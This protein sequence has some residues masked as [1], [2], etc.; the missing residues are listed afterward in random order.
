M[1]D[2]SFE[3]LV[4]EHS[5]RV[6]NCA[7][8]ILGNAELADD[9]HQEVFMAIW[10]RWNKYD[11]QVKWSAYLYKVTVRKAIELARRS[12]LGPDFGWELEHQVTSQEPDAD[13]R[14]AEL[15]QKLTL[16]L[17]KLP[18][19]QAEV[20]VLSKIEG[21]GYEA[22]AEILGCSQKTARV[23]LHRAVKQLARDLSGYLH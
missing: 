21:L 13:I 19:R 11:G 14:A 9:V 20:F 4:N 8:R 10:R 18:E 12:R 23:H 16:C 5:R 1:S 7:L 17:A 15:Q 22:I 3:S 2:R 6:L